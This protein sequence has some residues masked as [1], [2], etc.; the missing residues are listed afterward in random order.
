MMAADD[1]MRMTHLPFRQRVEQT[2]QS[3]ATRRGFR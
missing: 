2:Q 1:V 3:A